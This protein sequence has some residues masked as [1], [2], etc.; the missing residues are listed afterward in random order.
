MQS[1]AYFY[2]NQINQK[3][4]L[5]SVSS[6]NKLVFNLKDDLPIG[7]YSL[8]IYTDLKDMQGKYQRIGCDVMITGENMTFDI[9]IDQTLHFTNV[10]AKAGDN[11]VY[12][13]HFNKAE[14]L[15]QKLAVLKNTIEQYPKDDEFY[16]RL[17]DQLVKIELERNNLETTATDAT[18]KLFPIASYYLNT[19]KKLESQTIDKIDF[20]NPLLKNS[21]YI[22]ML[23]WNYLDAAASNNPSELT[24]ELTQRLATILPRLKLDN[25]AYKLMVN[26]ILNYYE[27]KGLNEIV[28]LLNEQYLL[29]EVCESTAHTNSIQEKNETLKKVLIGQTAPDFNLSGLNNLQKLSD[30]KSNT[31]LLLFWE[32]TC[33]HCQQLTKELTALYNEKKINGFE[34]LAVALDTSLA[35]YTTYIKENHLAWLNVSDSGGWDGSVAK[36]YNIKATPQMYLLDKDK[37]ILAKPVSVSELRGLLL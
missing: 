27:T 9:D 14:L 3:V 11:Q 33:H 26:E 21:P 2:G 35:A 19:Q 10:R 28:L 23:V 31:T 34:V 15:D 36:E 24:K 17:K 12:Y 1:K 16:T 30:I 5:D 37:K 8:M 4:L 6:D 13:E 20:T 32:S 18:M 25:E 7:L 29:P 22:P